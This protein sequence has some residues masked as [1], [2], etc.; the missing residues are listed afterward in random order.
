MGEST[1]NLRVGVDA[2]DVSELRRWLSLPTAERFL[3]NTYTDDELLYCGRD[4]SRLGA[5]WAAKEAVAKAI[6]SGFRGIA[7]NDIDIAHRQDGAPVVRS[8]SVRKWPHGA[9]R[10]A[11]SVSMSHEKDLAVAVAIAVVP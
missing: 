10:W 1:A 3:A 2:C 11:W 5:R 6:G 8:G 7:P 4:A 9:E